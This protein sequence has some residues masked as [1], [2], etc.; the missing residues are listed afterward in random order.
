MATP[1][2]SESSRPVLTSYDSV[3]EHSLEHYL[4][5]RHLFEEADEGFVF[6]DRFSCSYDFEM[7]A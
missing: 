2:T 7:A 3:C 5:V 1:G 4:E 6:G